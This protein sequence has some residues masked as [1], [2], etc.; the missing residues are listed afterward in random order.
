MVRDRSIPSTATT[1]AHATQKQSHAFVP[2]GM[3]GF[4]VRRS[5]SCA[6]AHCAQQENSVS[7]ACVSSQSQPVKHIVQ[8]ESI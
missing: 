8:S 4:S 5:L 6:E 3:K 7:M 2:E 1:M